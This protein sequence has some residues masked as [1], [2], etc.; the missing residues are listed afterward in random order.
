MQLIEVMAYLI[1][2]ASVEYF[3]R[4]FLKKRNTSTVVVNT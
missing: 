1:A 3:L 2:K 4:V